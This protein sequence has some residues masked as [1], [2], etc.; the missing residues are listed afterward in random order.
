MDRRQKHYNL[1][2]ITE[3]MV[4]ADDIVMEYLDTVGSVSDKDHVK[5][6]MFMVKRSLN[7]KLTILLCIF[8]K[9][10]GSWLLNK[11]THVTSYYKFQILGG[12]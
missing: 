6:S 9:S 5:R 1:A 4:A 10:L 2:K 7:I 11:C 12:F 3:L 8:L